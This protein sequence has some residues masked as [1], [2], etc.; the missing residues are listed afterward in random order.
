MSYPC[1]T[2]LYSCVY[3]VYAQSDSSVESG[4]GARE[5]DVLDEEED[6]MAS[7]SFKLLD[8]LPLEAV[9]SKTK[10]SFSSAAKRHYMGLFPH[11][12]SGEINQ[13]VT[14]KWQV[15]KD[16]AKSLPDELESYLAAR[17]GKKGT[18]MCNCVLSIVRTVDS[19]QGTSIV[20]FVC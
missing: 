6:E 12:T 18:Y 5:V 3:F 14:N 20:V 4:P 15:L 16:T 13:I 11:A 10:A 17:Q 7:R 1:V 8:D 19:M 9:L 2:Y